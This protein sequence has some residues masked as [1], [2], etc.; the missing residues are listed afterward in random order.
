MCLLGDLELFELLLLF[1][2]ANVLFLC[3]ADVSFVV[4]FCFLCLMNFV[5]VFNLRWYMLS[6]SLLSS[7]VNFLIF[8]LGYRFYFCVVVSIFCHCILRRLAV[9]TVHVCT[10]KSE[11]LN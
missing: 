5:L 3:V 10:T 6:F 4:C 11:A 8:V 1:G 2:I 7:S 9:S